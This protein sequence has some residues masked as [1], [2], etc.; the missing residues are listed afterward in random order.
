M[1]RKIQ[2]GSFKYFFTKIFVDWAVKSSYR[3]YQ[4]EGLENLPQNASVIWASNHTNA[5]MDPLVM[6]SATKQQ[7]VFVARA[8][9]FKKKSV[10]KILTFLKIMPIYRIRDGIEAVRHNNESIA[11]ATDV[12]LDGVPFVIYPEATHRPK[13]SLLK[14][15][16]GIFHIAESAIEHTDEQKS[17]YIQPIGIEYG[18]YFRFR[19]TVLIR[20]GKPLD[21]TAFMKEHSDLQQPVAML[22]LRELLTESLAGLIAYVPDD[23][24]YDATWE[25]A[26][27]KADNPHYFKDKVNLI[28]KRD[29][30]RLRGLMKLQA[31]DRFAIQEVIDLKA[32]NPES[33][34]NLLDKVDALRVWRIQNGVSVTSIAGNRGWFSILLRI[35]LAILGAPY[36]FFSGLVSCITWIPLTI[37]LRGITDEAF[38][39]TAR[40]GV[41]FAMAP[42][43]VI[44]WAVLFFV[45][46]PWKIALAAFVL[47]LPSLR[48][49]Y[50][51]GRFFR[52]L[53]SDLRWKIGGSKAP[54][55][56]FL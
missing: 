37:I 41:R 10:I 18:D 33:A 1:S 28:E 31:V 49:I 39:N 32:Q 26:K 53:C 8:D 44:L 54:D 56:S 35:L 38:N 40:F 51:Y 14:L 25:Y 48:Y 21:I 29:N 17:V 3:K 36:Y 11:Q 50:A 20:F 55:H 15:S 5:L 4:V 27:L 7:K 34:R 2:D 23:E 16:K 19:S 30:I 13:H 6:L 52:R 45:F 47:S 42:L 22:R 12:L 24:D 9:I 43:S 46:L